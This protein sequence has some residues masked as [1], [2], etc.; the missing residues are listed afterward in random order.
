V[1]QEFK[2]FISKGNIIE[3]AVAVVMAT[4]FAPV[5]AA[6]V[7]GIL[8]QVVAM[9]FGE[10]NFGSLNFT[11][12]DAVFAY[13]AVINAIITFVFTALAVFFVL[14]A[15]NAS[16]ADEEAAT[17]GPSEVDLLTEI[18]DSLAKG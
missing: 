9:I 10:P 7:N 1:L 8:M 16:K 2:D 14:K 13:G 17:S 5:I 6:F 3:L 4:A 12:N 18:R 11:L 15:Y